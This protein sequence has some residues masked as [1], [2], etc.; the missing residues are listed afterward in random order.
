MQT[1]AHKDNTMQRERQR[2]RWC[3]YKARNTEDGQQPPEAKRQG[4]GQSLPRGS[5]EEPTM[6]D[7]LASRTM[8]QYIS[9]V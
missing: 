4:L 2:S 8:R 6:G 1:H 7:F 3:F 5:Q 9:I